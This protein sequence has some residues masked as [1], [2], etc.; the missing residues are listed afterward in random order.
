MRILIAVDGTHE[1]EAALPV[2]SR[3]ARALD[4]D[5]YLLQVLGG[6]AA[7]TGHVHHEPEWTGGIEPEVLGMMKKARTY[8]EELAVQHELPAERTR[9]LVGRSESPAEEIITVARNSGT[10][11]IVM[12]SHCGGWLRQLTKGSVCSEVVHSKVC[13]VLCVPVHSEAGARKQRKHR[14]LMGARS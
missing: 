7:T 3:L 4:A 14:A 5:V 9:C 13:P 2:A 12:S 8:L 11:L 10:D 1:C 6:F